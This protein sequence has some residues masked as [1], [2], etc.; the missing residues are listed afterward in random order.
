MSLYVRVNTNFF[1]HRKTA[2]L[3]AAIGDA[4]LWLPIRLWTYAAENQADG[5]FSAYSAA[6]LATLLG[7]QGD[8]EAMLQALLQAS[9]MDSN[10]LRIHD[11]AEYNGY[12]VTY[13]ER[14]KKA[15]AARW[16]KNPLPPTPPTPEKELT[17]EERRGEEASNATSMLQASKPSK[18]PSGKGPS[19]PPKMFPSEVAREL[20]DCREVYA[21]IPWENSEAWKKVHE[22]I[23]AFE[24]LRF[25]EGVV[26][27]RLRTEPATDPKLIDIRTQIIEAKSEPDEEK[28]KRILERL[29]WN[30]EERIQ[31]LEDADKALCK[32]ILE[33]KDKA[34]KGKKSISRNPGT[35]NQNTAHLYTSE[36]ARRTVDR[37]IGNANEGNHE[38]KY[39]DHPK[40]TKA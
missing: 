11:W 5:D 17:R 24:E 21:S 3:R 26:R 4:A 6:E 34:P 31:Q 13:A 40:V 36:V 10:P 9:F 30:E 18:Q 22:K 32:N 27:T 1:T 12:H 8:A 2:R 33:G 37:N 35:F 19:S 28:R 25:G 16:A 7:Y 29:K 14:A 38:K 39:D 20:A 23:V 15:A